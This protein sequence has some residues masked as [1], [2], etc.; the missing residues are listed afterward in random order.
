MAALAIITTPP[1]LL[2]FLTQRV[3]PGRV[4]QLWLRA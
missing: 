1:A 2:V 3:H 4:P